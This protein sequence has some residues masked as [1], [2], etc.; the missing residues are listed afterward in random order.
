MTDSNE[1]ESFRTLRGF[2]QGEEP[3][4]VTYFAYSATLRIYGQDLCFEEI[5][6]QLGVEPTHVHR[7]GERRG[8]RS[9][10]HR[11]D[12]WHFSPGLS[13]NESLERHIESL[14]KT[15]KPKL[16]YLKSLKT[17]YNIDVFCGYRTNC[18]HAGIQVSHTCLELFTALEVP[19]GVSI[20]IA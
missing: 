4:E 3:D 18:D 17:Q 14:W 15:L 11:E 13:E 10:G 1:P 8:P 16:D 6:A 2:L 5:S 19:F 20:I 9:P 12:A 7:K